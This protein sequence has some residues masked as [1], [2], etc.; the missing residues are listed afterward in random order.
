MLA[1]RRSLGVGSQAFCCV[2]RYTL[3]AAG[4]RLLEVPADVTVKSDVALVVE[5]AKAEFERIDVLVNN[6][7]VVGIH[8][9]EIYPEEALIGSWR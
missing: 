6:A 7:G 8:E 3:R 2:L 5:R 9:L 1:G 4:R